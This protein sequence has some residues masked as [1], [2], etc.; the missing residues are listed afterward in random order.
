[1]QHHKAPT[2]LLDWTE[3]FLCAL[4]FAVQPEDGDMGRM[5][6]LAPQRL[7]R[8]VTGSATVFVSDGFHVA[9]RAALARARDYSGWCR[10]LKTLECFPSSIDAEVGLRF[11]EKKDPRARS[12]V[13]LWL[14]TPIAVRPNRFNARILA[15]AGTFTI[16]GG[17][18]N[19]HRPRAKA[20][21]DLPSALD[22]GEVEGLLSK[23]PLLGS[24]DVW[25]RPVREQL[26]QMGIHKGTLFPDLDGQVDFLKERWRLRPAES[27]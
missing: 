20:G 3:N 7:N 11:A 24:F 1:M 15:Q 27:D 10:E 26:H 9:M 14:K 21:A 17:K 19:G 2:R 12:A 18:L 4:Y 5:F 22:L 6:L 16:H 13:H 25:K 23:K 8:A